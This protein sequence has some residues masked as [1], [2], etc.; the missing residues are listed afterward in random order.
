MVHYKSLWFPAFG[1]HFPVGQINKQVDLLL[2]RKKNSAKGNQKSKLYWLL[3]TWLYRQK[4]KWLYRLYLG[5]LN[6]LDAGLI[7]VWNGKKFRQA[8][9]VLAAEQVGKKVVYFERGPLPGYSCIDPKGVNAF[10]SIPRS[11]EFYKKRAQ[12]V[13]IKKKS[14]TVLARPQGLPEHYV[15]VP[16][17]VV[18]DSNIYLHSPWIRSMRHLY[19][20]LELAL[21]S[22]PRVHFVI[23][24]HPA[25]P[26]NYEDLI[27][28]N[29]PNIRFVQDVTS[30]A[31]VEYAQAVL[32]VN[33]TVGI[34]AL[35]AHK[36]VIVLGDALYGFE[37]LTLPVTG[38]TQLETTV[39]RLDKWQLDQQLIDCF[40]DYLEKDYAIEGDAMKTP[41]E[42]HWQQVS[43]KLS[44]IL[45]GKPMA[46]IGLKD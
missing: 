2:T 5:W 26:E 18:E 45:S 29:N 36:K 1:V 15:F 33:S 42:K 31:L 9:L 40:L 14:K 24:P 13:Q 25:C 35:M 38:Q 19:H 4:A 8:I 23:K 34:E 16:F 21:E 17:Q 46:S 37:P 22:C 20:V 27:A 44:M 30:Q 28:L 10:S 7:G 3:F 12:H 39:C 11:V 43:T 6:K 32:T 41:T